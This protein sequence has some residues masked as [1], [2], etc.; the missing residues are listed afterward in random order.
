MM[1]RP[2]SCLWQRSRLES[3]VDGALG[4]RARRAVQDHLARCP[5]C[6]VRVE[7]IERMRGLLRSTVTPPADLDWST[8]WVGVERRIRT[9]APRPVGNRWWRPLWKPVWGHPRLASAAALALALLTATLWMG[10][11]DLG[12]AGETTVTVQ[13]ATT[14]SKGS[15]MVY[16]NRDHDMTVVWVLAADGTGGED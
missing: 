2:V 5:V 13:D 7:S 10:T 6:R 11:D 16:S 9:E 1:M 15:V 12:P 14:D 8:F 4:P 3:H